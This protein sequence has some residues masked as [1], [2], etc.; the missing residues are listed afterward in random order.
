MTATVRSQFT[1]RCDAPRCEAW[2]FSAL[3]R[4]AARRQAQRQGWTV[5]VN[6]TSRTTGDDFC[7]DH[8]PEGDNR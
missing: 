1:V 8:K 3:S 7:P 2:V 4:A 5:N 6:K